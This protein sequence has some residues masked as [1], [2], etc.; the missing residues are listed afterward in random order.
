M[1]VTSE[2]STRR[3]TAR[4]FGGDSRTQGSR[5]PGFENSCS[6]QIKNNIEETDF[7]AKVIAL[8][9]QQQEI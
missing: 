1:E 9:M 8:E 6:N 2:E 7:G 3:N 5:N 4:R